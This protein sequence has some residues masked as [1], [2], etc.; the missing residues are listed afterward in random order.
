MIDTPT[1]LTRNIII[2]LFLG[3]AAGSFLSGTGHPLPMEQ[4]AKL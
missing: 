2:G 3:F 1:N 4:D